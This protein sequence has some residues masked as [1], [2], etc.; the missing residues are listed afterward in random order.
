MR[1]WMLLMLRVLFYVKD[2]V[3][4]L[5]VVDALLIFCDTLEFI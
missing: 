3:E 2:V 1:F 5:D 4:V